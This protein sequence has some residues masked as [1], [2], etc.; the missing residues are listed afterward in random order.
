MSEYI[1]NEEKALRDKYNGVRPKCALAECENFT[2]FRNNDYAAH[3]SVSCAHKNTWRK[4]GYKENHNKTKKVLGE[5]PKCNLDGCDNKVNLGS[6]GYRKF[7]SRSCSSKQ[8]W[9]SPEYEKI[10]IDSVNSMWADLEHRNKMGEI[11]EKQWTNPEFRK[12]MEKIRSSQ[13]YIKKMKEAND[14]RWA[15]QEHRTMMK[16]VMDKIWAD[17]EFRRMMRLTSSRSLRETGYRRYEPGQSIYIYCGIFGDRVVKVGVTQNRTRVSEME[18]RGFRIVFNAYIDAEHAMR[19]E[20]EYMDKTEDHLYFEDDSYDFLGSGGVGE[21]RH[22]AA[23]QTFR[24]IVW[25][26]LGRTL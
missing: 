18:K 22:V 9:R 17:L 20:T 10:M 8:N 14:K 13:E 5:A 12:K 19:I 4:P 3:C 23:L 24:N 16:E 11:S 6:N 21:L 7:C 15:D 26:V 25:R 1:T 2:V